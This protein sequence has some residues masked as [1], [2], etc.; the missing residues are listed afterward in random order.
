MSRRSE[1]N[2]QPSDFPFKQQSRLSLAATLQMGCDN[3]S[4]A[5]HHSSIQAQVDSIFNCRKREVEMRRPH[6]PRKDDLFNAIHL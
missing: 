6:L 1:P 2:I 5:N 4:Y 3:P